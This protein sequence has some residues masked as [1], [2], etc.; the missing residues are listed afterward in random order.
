MRTAQVQR[1]CADLGI[2]RL[3][4]LQQIGPIRGDEVMTSIRLIRELIPEFDRS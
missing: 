3:I 1:A 4:C 2:N